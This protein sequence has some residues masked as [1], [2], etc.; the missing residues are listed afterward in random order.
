VYRRVLAFDYDG[1]LA[2]NGH[3]PSTLQNTLKQLHQAGYALF[4]VTGRQYETVDLGELQP[5]FAGIVWENGAVLQHVTADELYLPFGHVDARLIT[6][7]EKAHAPLEHGLA[8]ASTWTKHEATVWQLLSDTGSDAVI[9]HNKGALM[10]LPPG[11]AKGPGLE[12]LLEL[13]GFSPRN[14]VSF[15]DGE[16]DLSLFQSSETSIAVADAVPSLKAAADMVTN[17]SGP[18]GVQATLETYW[19]NNQP[20]PKTAARHQRLIALGKDEADEMVSLPG[21]SLVSSNLGI[22]GDSGSG[23]SWVTGLLAEGMHVAG[24]QV[25]LIDPEGDFRGL[26]S[27][28]GIIALNGDELTLPTP[29]VVITL[30]EEASIS[31]VLDLC[32]Y[33]INKRDAYITELLQ[34]LRP[35]KEHKFRPHWIV[36]EE[37]QHFLP[38]DGNEISAALEPMLTQGGWAFVSYRP[39]R[40]VESL[41]TAIDHC[42]LARLSDSEAVQAV[43]NIINIPTAEL[44]ANT[45]DGHIWLCGQKL[46]RLRASGRRVPHVRHLYKYLDTPLPKEKRFYFHTNQGFLGVTAASLFEFK[47]IIANLQLESL[48]YHQERGDFAA[49]IR[50]VLA[51][52]V[53]AAHIDK[54]AHRKDLVGEAMRQALL[55]RVLSRYAELHTLR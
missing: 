16:N 47:E 32:S 8:I 27:L 18:G 25:L 12:R 10:I 42:L 15:G 23:K 17:L 35:L 52:E 43:A 14:L 40:L 54:I 20:F 31:V 49:W 50:R 6:A 2:E 19:L 39:D 48:T 38:P 37:A 13:C 22:F 41:L 29:S 4:L 7:L 44:L 34:R 11:A 46:V 26:R 9:V 24:Y 5:I 28:P 55:Q 1:T 30:L 53:L 33:P 45:S 3:V 21:D 36:L 51:D